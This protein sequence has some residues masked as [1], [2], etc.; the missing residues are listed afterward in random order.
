MKEKLAIENY[1]GQLL[2]AHPTN[3]DDNLKNSVIL[4]VSYASPMCLGLQ[5]NKTIDHIKLSNICQNMDIDY[6]GDENLYHGGIVGTGKVHV[7]HST[8]WRGPSTV[9]INDYINVTSDISVLV[10]LSH[11]GGPEH[12]RAC[13]GYWTW[14]KSLLDNQLGLGSKGQLTDYR[15]EV[16]PANTE[17]V[18]S[19]DGDDQ[20]AHC[21]KASTE[22][23][24]KY[25]F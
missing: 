4:V 20:W 8:D 23:L 1:Q 24:V 15:W 12:F 7:V 2:I 25:W 11:G 13:A 3:P 19:L 22:L 17:H 21:V 6:L 18:F 14:S 9:Q 10:A 5:I 16:L